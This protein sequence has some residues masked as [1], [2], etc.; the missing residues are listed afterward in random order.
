MV[1]PLCRWGD[2]ELGQVVKGKMSSVLDM[3]RKVSRDTCKNSDRKIWSLGER[4]G[5][6]RGLEVIHNETHG[7]GG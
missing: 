7:S 1:L 5:L 4:V 2:A 3:W 6:K